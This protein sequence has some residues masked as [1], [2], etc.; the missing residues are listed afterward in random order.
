MAIIYRCIAQFIFF[1]I[2]VPSESLR[3]YITAGLF[4]FFVQPLFAS[5]QHDSLQEKGKY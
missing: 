3:G 5:L 2:E 4:S 1:E